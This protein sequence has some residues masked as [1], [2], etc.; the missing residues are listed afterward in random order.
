VIEAEHIDL[1][2]PRARRHP[3]ELERATGVGNGE[4]HPIALR[5]LYGRARDRLSF[6]FDHSALAKADGTEP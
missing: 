6:G 5:R 3:V 4:E 1:D 2:D